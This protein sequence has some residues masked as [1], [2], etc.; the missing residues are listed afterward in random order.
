MNWL[1]S[2]AKRGP[3]GGQLAEEALDEDVPRPNAELA[4]VDHMISP[5]IQIHSNKPSAQ[6]PAGILLQE[7]SPFPVW[8][9]PQ[10]SN[11]SASLFRHPDTRG[12]LP[13]QKTLA[14]LNF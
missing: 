13:I 2:R 12:L 11:N 8:I 14:F 3:L 4:C 6:E 7:P 10:E 1:I 5:S 9:K